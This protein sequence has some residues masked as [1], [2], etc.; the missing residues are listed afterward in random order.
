MTASH[1]LFSA[2][3]AE[4]YERYMVSV[5]FHVYAEDL[6]QRIAA[7]H[8]R[9]VLEIAAGTG[10]LTRALAARLGP[11]TEIVGT[12][13]SPAMLE[14]AQTD[15]H[16]AGNSRMTWRL[17]DA[18]SLPFGE[19]EFDVAACQFGV[20]FFPDKVRGYRETRRVL[21]PGGA[22]VFNVWD[23]IAA[24]D[25]PRAIEDAIAPLFGGKAPDFMTRIPHGYHNPAQIESD[26]RAAGFERVAFEPRDE[27]ARVPSARHLALAIC[28]GTP[29]RREIEA[30]TT[31]SLDDVT[32]FA[33]QRLGEL[34]GNGPL[35]GRMRALVVSARRP[36]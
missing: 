1:D 7:L 28:Q 5:F 9:R 29:L 25:L 32:A 4:A 35:E 8:P 3:I 10:V 11:D 12:D 6:A 30:R 18:L 19:A 31:L 33:E 20:M 26:L 27:V 13:L 17:A 14:R 21:K 2:A 16:L 15:P 23:D 22:F 24:N 36:S 34:L